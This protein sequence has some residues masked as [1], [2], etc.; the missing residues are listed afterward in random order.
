MR[1]AKGRGTDALKQTI[2]PLATCLLVLAILPHHRFGLTD[3]KVMALSAA[4]ATIAV[5]VVPY[6]WKRLFGRNNSNSN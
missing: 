3:V 1:I 5:F 2:L 4:L 6:L